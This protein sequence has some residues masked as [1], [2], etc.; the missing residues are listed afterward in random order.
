M[1]SVPP[2]P[3]GNPILYQASHVPGNKKWAFT[4]TQWSSSF[5]HAH[6]KGNSRHGD[7]GTRAFKALLVVVVAVR[8]DELGAD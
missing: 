1:C 5:V 7:M 4:Y 3:S 2:P 8:D 6:L